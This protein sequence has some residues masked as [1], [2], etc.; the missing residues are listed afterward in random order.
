MSQCHSNYIPIRYK[1]VNI[2]NTSKAISLIEF[3]RQ[4]HVEPNTVRYWLR[5]RK[6][7]G[8]KIGGRWYIYQA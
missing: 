8:Y 6:V 3:A 4:K 2:E 5:K 1:C 7:K